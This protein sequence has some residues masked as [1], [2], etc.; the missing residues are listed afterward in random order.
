MNA[1]AVEPLAFVKRFCTADQTGLPKHE[2]LR[3]A[4]TAAI[5][6]KLWGPGVRLPTETQ[7][8][9]ATPY[10]LGTVQRALRTLVEEGYIERR[11]GYG[12]YVPDR[13]GLLSDPLHC[14]FL[15]DDG[16]AFLPVFTVP[17]TRSI[18]GRHG[19]WSGPLRQGKD[20][21]I[22]IDRH[23]EIN[24]EFVVYSK[25]YVLATRMPSFRDAPLESL[26]GANLKMLIV[27][28]IG[29]PLTDFKQELY[30][31]CLPASICRHINVKPKTLSLVMEATAY[32]GTDL[33]AYYQEFYIP[34]TG[35]K[36]YVESRVPG[37]RMHP[38]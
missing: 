23:M 38:L 1:R 34:P 18:T 11:R 5:S 28:A 3:Q 7:L 35:R 25:F 32:A 12:T 9:T 13:R 21:V 29:R 10:S 6:Q 4:L 8:T 31:T 30:Q 27:R 16:R 20:D 24:G 22:E 2:V 37:M 33:P 26:S 15:S 17:L 36:L 19:A 14:R